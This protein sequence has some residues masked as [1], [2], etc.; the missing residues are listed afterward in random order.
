M[1][2]R[3]NMLKSMAGLELHPSNECIANTFG[4]IIHLPRP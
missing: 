1:S 4:H 2:I 3:A